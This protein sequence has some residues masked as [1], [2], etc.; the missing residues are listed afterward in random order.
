MTTCALVL[1][2]G[3]TAFMASLIWI[4]ETSVM[5]RLVELPA[6]PLTPPVFD[7]PELIVRRFEPKP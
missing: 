7:C 1:E 2:T 5:L 3:A 4:L 6:P